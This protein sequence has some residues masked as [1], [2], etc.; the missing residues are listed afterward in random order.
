MNINIVANDLDL[1]PSLRTYIEEKIGSIKKLVQK[2]DERGS[3]QAR[4]EVGR[5]T[6]HHHKGDV[7]RAEVN[8]DLAG[9]LF[10]AE[11]EN[12]DIRTAIDRAEDKLRRELEKEKTKHLAARHS[13][14]EE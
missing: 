10:R 7:F 6:R 8:L 11:D 4:V 5:T 3:V 12:E 14:K 13:G 9:K 1:T 2:F